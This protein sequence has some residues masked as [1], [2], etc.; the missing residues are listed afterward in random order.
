MFF[1]PKNLVSLKS[2]FLLTFLIS[3]RLLYSQ[4][5]INEGSNKN[6]S[7]ISDEDAEYPDWIELINTSSQ[8]V[9]L[10]GYSL[11]DDPTNPAQWVFSHVYIAAGEHL[12]IFCSGKDRIASPPFTT[13]LNTGYFNPQT[14]W[15]SH[16]FTTP[17][18]WDGV[19]NLLLNVCSY[20]SAGFVTNS[21]F[22]QSSTTVNST[23]FAFQDGSP[24]SCYS[25]T[26]Y[27]AMQRPNIKLNDFVVGTGTI[28]NSPYDYPAPYGNWY[29][30]ARNQIM[31]TAAELTAA[32]LTAGNLDSLAFDVAYT[33][34]VMYDYIELSMGTTMDTSMTAYF[35]PLTGKMHHTNFK[36]DGNGETVYLYNPNGNLLSS[37]YLNCAS[38]D[39]SVGS[40]P[41]AASFTTIFWPPTPGAT[42][43]SSISYTTFAQPPVFSIPSGFYNTLQSVYITNPN[44][45][46]TQVYY[47]TDGSDP[48]PAS[49]LDT[50]AAI[51]I[52]Q[53]T[54]LKARAYVSGYLPSSIT[55]STYFFNVSHVTPIISVITDNTNLYGVTGIFDN[56][57]QDWMRPAYVEYF[58]S[59]T[60]HNLV[61][62]QKTGMIMDGGLG[63]SRSQPQHSFRLDFADGV[64]GEG[65][66]NHA[67][68]P[69]RPNRTEYSKIYLRNGSNQYLV[70][71]YKD[72]SQ[73]KMMAG[74]TNTY[75]SGW[76]PVSVYI[77]GQYFGLYELR[78]KFDKEMFQTL[79]NATGS[80]VEIL[81]VSAFYGGVLRAVEGST[82]SFWDSYNSYAQI[83]PLDTNYWDQADP[84]FD[85]KYYVDYIIGEIWMGNVDWPWNNIK[86]YRSDATDYS[87]RFC[88]IDQELALLPNSWTDCTFDGIAYVMGQSSNDPFA[89]MFVR[90]I[91]NEKFK[92]YFINRYADVMN[93]AYDTSRLLYIEND[94]FNRTIIEMQNEYA[95][96]ADPFNVPAWINYF[97]DNHITFQSEL[98]CRT[99]T[100]RNHIQSNFTLPRQV[101]LTL[102]VDPPGA[103]TIHIST[104]TPD[105]YPWHGVYFDGVPVSIE[106]NANPGFTFSHW[107]NNSLLTDTLMALFS[108]TLQADT[109]VFKAY[110]D[111]VIVTGLGEQVAKQSDFIAYPSPVNQTLFIEDKNQ[112]AVK[113]GSFAILDVAGRT[114][115][116]GKLNGQ[117]GKT[118][119]DVKE[120]RSG[121][122][123]IKIREGNKDSGF[124]KFVKL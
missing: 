123:L 52:F 81:G 46:N 13:V 62:S 14:G 75:Y 28:Q 29:W 124:L 73:V 22:N 12:V 44:S 47:T 94:M 101:D 115:I 118:P 105:T 65:V 42:N 95:R 17:Y 38:Y 57:N 54:V 45:G 80:S 34:S 27:N 19:S 92:N 104:I 107:A 60:N 1:V 8:T 117:P 6:Y 4:I 5:E 120:L 31:Y 113:D 121:V 86:I 88:I 64:L 35:Y 53:S 55:T 56:Y 97:Y 25:T 36:I 16:A 103:G 90:G 30:G 59:T 79:E 68:I 116:S 10:Y 78:E 51:I 93:T 50:G 76:R 21:V 11:T 43:D 40:F 72:A 110:F 91:Q 61:F 71:P 87:W 119:V 106:A 2:I 66:V 83:N 9:D 20:N 77:N 96:W 109:I 3:S 112:T 24:A 7:T 23:T 84:Y 122:Y 15:N 67:I 18:F 98:I 41:D 26:G 114:V 32:G 82:T 111:T 58:D 102:E 33:D 37:L 70:L 100:V 85:Q 39:L 74:E 69:D 48:T 63:G 49:T 108:D 89:G 99:P